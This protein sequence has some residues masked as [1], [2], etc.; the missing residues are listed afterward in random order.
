MKE[1]FSDLPPNQ[2]RKKLNAKILELQQKITQETAAYDGLM[3]MKSVYE[4]NSLLGDPMTVEGQLNESG[5]KLERL[6]VELRKFMAYLEV[7]NNAQNSPQTDRHNM[8]HNGGGQ[9]SSRYVHEECNRADGSRTGY[10]NII[11]SG[12]CDVRV[13]VA[14]IPTAVMNTMRAKTIQTMR[15]V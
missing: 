4:S 6:K 3:K 12:T 1:D 5:N 14:D 7:A 9:R 8:H 2:R 11:D 13:F 15:A 10:Q